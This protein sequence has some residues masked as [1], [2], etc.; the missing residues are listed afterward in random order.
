MTRRR[1]N[2]RCI[3]DSI[4]RH[5]HQGASGSVVVARASATSSLR[6]PRSKGAVAH[7]EL[8]GPRS[9]GRP[10]GAGRP[11]R[12]G[13]CWAHRYEDDHPRRR[14]GGMDETRYPSRRPRAHE[15]EGRAE[16]AQAPAGE[17][18]QTADR[19]TG[20]FPRRE[21]LTTS[22]EI[23]ALFQQGKR[24]DRPSLVVLWRESDGPRRAGFA[25]TRQIRGAASRNRARRRLR[26]AF[27]A[28]RTAAPTGV[29]LM[30]IAER[31]ALQRPL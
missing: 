2:R 6:R 22:A 20:R 14:R 11:N 1:R 31:G 12:D 19:V 3:A 27:R 17:G 13:T 9:G 29:A 30:V 24:V 21:R 18:A 8:P 25:V 4:P 28:T 7:R 16:G 23:Q 10:N 5:D 15:D 26:E